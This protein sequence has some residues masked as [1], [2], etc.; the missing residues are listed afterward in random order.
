MPLTSVQLYTKSVIDQLSVPGT[1]QLVQAYVT[2]PAVGTLDNPVAVIEGGRLAGRRQTAPRGQGFKRLGWV[3][4]VYLAYLSNPDSET[5]DIEFPQVIDAVM[6]AF[7]TTTMPLF[8][9]P[10]GNRVDASQAS[11]ADSQILAIG[12]DFELEYPPER[13]PAS[14]RMVYYVARLGLDVYEAVQA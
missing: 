8:I 4:D 7:W 14:L 11:A 2:P 5:I 12:E 9:D 1:D 13:T 6:A 3:V 10:L